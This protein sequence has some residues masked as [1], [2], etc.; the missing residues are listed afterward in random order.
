MQPVYDRNDLRRAILPMFDQNFAPH[1]HNDFPGCTGSRQ[2][3]FLW[4]ALCLIIALL[5]LAQ[6]V[7]GAT[8]PDSKHHSAVE[9]GSSSARE[10]PQVHCLATGDG[11]LRARLTGSIQAELDWRN[12]AMNCLG[13]VR[14]GGGLRLRFGH[15]YGKGAHPLVLLF[16]INA[17]HEG[18]AGK[19]LAAN[20]TIMREGKGEFYSTQGDKCTIDQLRQSL[21]P[22]VPTRKRSYRVE[23][24]GFCEQPAHALNGHGMVLVTR[25][26]FAGRVDVD[27]GDESTVAMSAH[28]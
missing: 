23:A 20:L 26:D 6:P 24:H 19:V 13:S 7:A 9:T 22:G 3:Y 18:E 27:A 14:P 1:P 15:A 5:P 16:G 10:K 11:Y 28:S 8:G 21:V 4:C 25:F 12:D 2:R 17:I